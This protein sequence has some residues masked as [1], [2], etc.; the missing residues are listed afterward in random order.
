MTMLL[1]CFL[2]E[3]ISLNAFFA[4]CVALLLASSAAVFVITRK[5]PN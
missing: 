2:S 5:F 4:T 1:V 3:A